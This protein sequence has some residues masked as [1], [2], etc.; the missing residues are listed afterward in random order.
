VGREKKK[1]QP[2]NEEFL[3]KTKFH[4]TDNP[5]EVLLNSWIGG[6]WVD[7]TLFIHGTK[8]EIFEK[9]TRTSGL[10]KIKN[11]PTLVFGPECKVLMIYVHLLRI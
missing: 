1:E 5:Q 11:C 8:T 10:I 4:S 9:Q 3:K 7:P 6:C 2:R